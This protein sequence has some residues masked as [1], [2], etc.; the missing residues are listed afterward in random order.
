[1]R[2]SSRDGGVRAAVL[3]VRGIFGTRAKRSVRLAGG[4]LS[5]RDKRSDES[6]G[7]HGALLEVRVAECYGG[8]VADRRRLRISLVDAAGKYVVTLLFRQA[9]AV[10]DANYDDWLRALQIAHQCRLENYYIVN[11]RKRSHKSQTSSGRN[12]SPSP[13]PTDSPTMKPCVDRVDSQY[14]AW[15]KHLS[16]V[17]THT[18]QDQSDKSGSDSPVMSVDPH[19]SDGSNSNS[20]TS[21]GNGSGNGSGNGINNAVQSNSPEKDVP[22][23]PLDSVSQDPP[24]L[25]LI[26]KGHYAKVFRAIH[27][28]TG[29]VVAVKAISKLSSKDASKSKSNPDEWS[30]LTVSPLSSDDLDHN[31]SEAKNR[32]NNGKRRRNHSHRHGE[33]ANLN[34][35][36]KAS[37]VHIQREAEIMRLVSHRN[38]VR[39]LDVFET[40]YTLYIV[41]ELAPNGTLAEVFDA[42]NLDEDAARAVIKQILCAIA[43]LHD[44][45]VIH[46]DI[47]PENILLAADGT[48]KLADFGLSRTMEGFYPGEYCLSSVLGT[49]SY[50]APEIAS[51]RH[52]GFPVDCWSVG[53]ILH[54]ALTGRFPFKAKS[55][56]A[57][58]HALKT[59]HKIPFPRARWACIS[60]AARDLVR[61]LLA[62]NPDVRLT[63]QEAL[64]HPWFAGATTIRSDT[65]RVSSLISNASSV[66]ISSV[67]HAPPASNRRE[68]IRE[69]GTAIRNSCPVVHIS[70]WSEHNGTIPSSPVTSSPCHSPCPSPSS[71]IRSDH[72][73]TSPMHCSSPNTTA[74]LGTTRISRVSSSSSSRAERLHRVEESVGSGSYFTGPRQMPRVASASGVP[75]SKAYAPPVHQPSPRVH[76]FRRT[77]SHSLRSLAVYRNSCRLRRG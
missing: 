21:N 12:E 53:I 39:C 44:S 16:S 66:T 71:S 72:S 29:Q 70:R 11:M 28:E 22:Q 64:M 41:M 59:S 75:A 19:D 25:G 50:V 4:V 48:L 46:R 34:V 45:G 57:V 63:A 40:S 26:G 60:P 5:V 32:R 68:H 65:A 42:S 23:L 47:K 6:S 8:V 69:D 7:A 15:I 10:G 58:F 33:H 67:Q 30:D 37:P 2:H 61:G 17:S 14:G 1:M 77:P 43:Y 49:P 35:R 31:A 62:F 51:K 36:N 13:A 52:Y 38:V 27:R 3:H 9:V 18:P 54:L 20:S 55:P 73:P 76:S 24:P 56:E 74:V